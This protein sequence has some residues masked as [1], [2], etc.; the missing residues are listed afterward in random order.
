MSIFSKPKVLSQTGQYKLSKTQ[1]AAKGKTGKE[2]PKSGP[3]SG[4]DSDIETLQNNLA[5]A[6]AQEGRCVY[7][8]VVG[9]ILAA[10]RRTGRC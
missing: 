7:G 9:W 3:S 10:N 2:K 4:L 8:P 6:E 5:Q 1:V